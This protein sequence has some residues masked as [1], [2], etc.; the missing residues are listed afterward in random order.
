MS[1]A[2][3]TRRDSASIIGSSDYFAAIDVIYPQGSICTCSNGVI[4]FEAGD[5]TGEWMF[6]VPSM[7]TWTIE[8]AL[9]EQWGCSS[10]IIDTEG[11]RASTSIG[12]SLVL[13]D[14]GVDNISYTGGWSGWD[15]ETYP[16]ALHL[17]TGTTTSE[18]SSNLIQTNNLIDLAPYNNLHFRVT[19]ADKVASTQSGVANGTQSLGIS[20]G[21]G[22]VVSKEAGVSSDV[23]VDISNYDS[24]Y[25]IR[26]SQWITSLDGS[27]S[28]GDLTITKVWVD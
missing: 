7:G 18:G 4:T 16:E 13:F 23:R 2:F 14:Q 9:G 15:S 27:W 10:V 6:S 19:R 25:Y 22:Y 21:S 26:I 8:A 24:S 5:T 17:S 11:Q 12:F 3:I 1:E 28:Q 20:T